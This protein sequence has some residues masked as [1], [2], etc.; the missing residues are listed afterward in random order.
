M[1]TFN[2]AVRWL[3]SGIACMGSEVILQV[4][5]SSERSATLVTSMPLDAGMD[6]KMVIQ[7]SPGGECSIAL[8]ALIGLDSR[9]CTSMIG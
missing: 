9:M 8:V 5:L 7:T 3:M 2:V 4:M 6:E 1:D